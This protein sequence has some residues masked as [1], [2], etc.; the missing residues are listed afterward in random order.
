MSRRRLAGLGGRADVAP[1]VR[2][3]LRYRPGLLFQFDPSADPAGLPDARGP[4]SSSPT[5]CR[6]PGR[7]A[8]RRSSPGASGTGRRPSSSGSCDCTGSCP[9]WTRCWP[10]R[11]RPRCPGSRPSCTPWSGP[12]SRSAGPTRPR[13]RNFVQY[14]LRLPDEFAV[15]ALRD[16]LAV[17]PKLVGLPAVQQWIA[18]AR[19][20]GLFLAA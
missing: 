17:N 4:G 3:F 10:G 1:E 18:Q 11:T 15:L 2:A 9:T 19:P 7:P 14:A 16:A 6:R 12:W 5:S 8:A 20:K 13:W